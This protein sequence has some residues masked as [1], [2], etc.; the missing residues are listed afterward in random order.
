[1]ASGIS[2]S[3]YVNKILKSD[4][5]INN[6]VG[7]QVYPL[8]ADQNTVYPFIIHMRDRI[9]T[10]YSK[11]GMI[12]DDVY[13]TVIVRTK[14]Y[15][16]GIEIAEIVREIFGNRHDSIYQEVRLTSSSERYNEADDSFTQ[17]LGFVAKNY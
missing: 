16:E 2:I 1:M 9:D 8:I 11:D 7:M 6:F 14:T 12:G 10:L 5:S 3:E 17:E 4:E 15:G 13:F